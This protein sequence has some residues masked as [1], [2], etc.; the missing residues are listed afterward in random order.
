M[1]QWDLGV[2]ADQED[3]EDQVEQEQEQELPM[4]D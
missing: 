3:Q 2:Q 1:R 4:Y